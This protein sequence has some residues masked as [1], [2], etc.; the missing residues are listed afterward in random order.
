[1]G[2]FATGLRLVL[3]GVLAAFLTIG[4]EA[5]AQDQNTETVTLEPWQSVITSQIE[6][7]RTKDAAGAFSYAGA[8]F[9]VAFP[10]AEA[11]FNAI[12]TA[13]YAPIMDS[14]SHSFGKFQ[15]LGDKAV[16][17]E[18]KFIGTDQGLYS[19]IYMLAEEANGWRAQGV[20]L[21]KEAGVGI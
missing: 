3:A 11:F 15:K 20:Q 2:L 7:F 16:A 6:A 12:V 1:M 5:R 10:S 13:G 21:A 18:V 9:Q 17:Q 8:G 19:A 14:R 4:M